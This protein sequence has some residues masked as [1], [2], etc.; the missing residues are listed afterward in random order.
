MAHAVKE[1]FPDVKLA[2]GPAIA[3]GF[4]YDLDCKHSI[5]Q[6]D[7]PKIEKKMKEII[8]AK[9]PFVRKEMSRE[10][11]I[12]LFSKLDE[13]YKVELLND[14]DDDTVT[15]YEEGN[16]TD[17]CRGPHLETT[18]RVKL[19]SVAGAY[20]RGDEN[21]KMLQR[22][23]GTAFPTKDELKKHLDFLEEVKK[24]DHRRL[25]KELDLF[26]D[27]SDLT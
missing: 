16:F 8:K 21:N 22:I 12:A 6:E 25:G 2:I 23:Y 15:V 20:W 26:S 14:L 11:A 27:L 3:D 10:D 19:L 17:M 9:S 13:T 18:G 24:R 1:L 4:Y 5:T 7:L